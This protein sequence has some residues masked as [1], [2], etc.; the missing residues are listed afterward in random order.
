M[1]NKQ[2]N[3]EIRK[4]LEKRGWEEKKNGDGF[5]KGSHTIRQSDSGNS[6]VGDLG[7]ITNPNDLNKSKRY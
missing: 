6:W 3:E 2:Q 4:E 7:K 1:A 5:Q